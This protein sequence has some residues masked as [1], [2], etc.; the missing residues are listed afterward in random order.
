MHGTV[1]VKLI[2][3]TTTNNNTFRKVIPILNTSNVKMHQFLHPTHVTKRTL[4][5][6]TSPRPPNEHFQIN[7]QTKP[8]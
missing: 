8:Q 2:K 7:L 5:K 6:T 3:N 1:N 4:C